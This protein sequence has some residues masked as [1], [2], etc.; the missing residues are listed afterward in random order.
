MIHYDF[1]GVDITKSKLDVALKAHEKFIEEVF[2]NN[3]EGHEKFVLWLKEHT[4]KAFVCFNAMGPHCEILAECLGQNGI[5]VS[6]VN[7]VRIRHFARHYAR[8]VLIRN[9]HGHVDAKIIASYAEKF[10][11]R[12]FIHQL[13]DQKRAKE[14]MQLIET[15][16]KQKGQFQSQLESVRSKEIRKAIVKM[17]KWIEKRIVKIEKTLN[18]CT[19]N[20]E[21]IGEKTASHLNPKQMC[22]VMR[23]LINSYI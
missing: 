20:N 23:K 22:A 3:S 17:I 10:V 6:V 18:N 2:A 11:P 1:V 19:Q 4:K 21:G 13:A 8:S 7:P 16:L 5:K 15:L 9:K 14:S 12:E